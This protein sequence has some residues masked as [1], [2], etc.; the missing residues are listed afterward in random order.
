MGDASQI[1][2]ISEPLFLGLE[3]TV[4]IHPVFTLEDVPRVTEEVEQ[5]RQ[6]Y[7]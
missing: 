4:Q 7:A 6:K 5:A 2:A 3:A 1:P